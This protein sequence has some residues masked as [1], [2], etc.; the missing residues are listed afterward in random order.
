MKKQ[1]PAASQP[2]KKKVLMQAGFLRKADEFPDN[3]QHP[4]TRARI[5][6]SP[7]IHAAPLPRPF[8]SRRLSINRRIRRHRWNYGEDWAQ[9]GPSGMVPMDRLWPKAPSPRACYH[10]AGLPASGCEG[11]GGGGSE[12]G[13]GGGGGSE[14]GTEGAGGGC[15]GCGGG[16]CGGCGG[17]EGCSCGG[18]CGCG[19]SCGGPGGGAG[20][21]AGQGG[22]ANEGAQEGAQEGTQEGT[23]GGGFGAG[24]GQGQGAGFGAGPGGGTPG[25]CGSP[26]GGCSCAACGC[27]GDMCGA[28]ACGAC[29]CGGSCAGGG[30]TI[31]VGQG[32]LTAGC[33]TAADEAAMSGSPSDFGFGPESLG[34]GQSFGL[35]PGAY[36]SLAAQM[37]TP[38]QMDARAAVA[39]AS[40]SSFSLGP[41]S[42]P[43]TQAAVNNAIAA[44]PE[45]Q[46][47]AEQGQLTA[48][49]QVAFGPAPSFGIT[50]E[51]NP[52]VAFS[53]PQSSPC[54]PPVFQPPDASSSEFAAFADASGAAA[55][56]DVSTS[57]FAGSTGQQPGLDFAT[58]PF[59]NVQLASAA[60]DQPF[61]TTPFGPTTPQ[62][63]INQDFGDLPTGHPGEPG[64]PAPDVAPDLSFP[65]GFNT[66]VIPGNMAAAPN[67]IGGA[68]QPMGGDFASMPS[69]V[70]TGG[71]L[72]SLFGSLAPSGGTQVASLGPAALTPE[73][74]PSQASLAA[75]GGPGQALTPSSMAFMGGTS[76]PNAARTEIASQT[77]PPGGEPPPPPEP[78]AAA[79]EPAPE[80]DVVEPRS[81]TTPAAARDEEQRA[82]ELTAALVGGGYVPAGIDPTRAMQAG[83]RFT[84]TQDRGLGAGGLLQDM[85]PDLSRPEFQLPGAGNLD[86]LTIDPNAPENR[87]VGGFEG[88]PLSPPGTSQSLES[89]LGLFDIPPT[90]FDS[91]VAPTTPPAQAPLQTMPPSP[92]AAPTSPLSLPEQLGAP[93]IFTPPSGQPDLPTG[94]ILAPEPIAGG[95]TGRGDRGYGIGAAPTLDAFGIPT[96]P[97]IDLSVPG[98]ID[99]LQA[100]REA[101][102]G[103]FAPITQPE[104]GM[105]APPG[106]GVAPGSGQLTPNEWMSLQGLGGIP[107]EDIAA[108]D[109]PQIYAPGVGPLGATIPVN[110]ADPNAPYQ[111]GERGG[112]LGPYDAPAATMPGP[113]G[114]P[115]RPGG[116]EE[117]V[118][119]IWGPGQGPLG[120]TIPS[121]ESSIGDRIAA[122]LGITP[123][124]AA[125]RA[126]V[127]NLATTPVE[128]PPD[129]ASAGLL[130]PNI[131]PGAAGLY[132]GTNQQPFA[133]STGLGTFAPAPS[134]EPVV[135]MTTAP[136]ATPTAADPMAP[137]DVIGNFLAG[138]DPTSLADRLSQGALTAPDVANLTN[139]A[140]MTAPPNAAFPPGQLAPSQVNPFGIVA[141]APG[142]TQVAKD[143]TAASTTDLNAGDR[144]SN[145]FGPFGPGV[146]ATPVNPLALPPGPPP[147]ANVDERNAR[148]TSEIASQFE[149]AQQADRGLG[150]VAPTTDEL[151]TGGRIAAAD[152]LQEYYDQLARAAP[153]GQVTQGFPV[154]P[155]ERAPLG[156]LTAPAAADRLLAGGNF[157]MAGAGIGN[158]T[159]QQIADRVGN[160]PLSAQTVLGATTTVSPNTGFPQLDLPASER[161]AQ[162]FEPLPATGFGQSNAPPGVDLQSATGTTIPDTSLQAPPFDQ[163][164]NPPAQP[165][166][167]PPSQFTPMAQPPVPSFPGGVPLPQARPEGIPVPTAADPLAPYDVIGDWLTGGNRNAA[168]PVAAPL[169]AAMR[170]PQS[171]TGGDYNPPPGWTGTPILPPNVFTPA[172]RT[173]LAPLYDP[174]A[175]EEPP[176]ASATPPAP[177]G[178][179]EIGPERL[180]RPGEERPPFTGAPVPYPGIGGLPPL[181]MSDR[182]L[183]Q[184]RQEFGRMPQAPDIPLPTP[185]PDIPAPPQVTAPPS[186]E[187]IPTDR[188][189]YEGRPVYT[190]PAPSQAMPQ[191]APAAIVP[192][193]AGNIPV[194]VIQIGQALM[195]GG[196]P[197]TARGGVPMMEG[198]GGPNPPMRPDEALLAAQQ[199]RRRAALGDPT[200]IMQLQLL[201]L[202]LSGQDVATM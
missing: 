105:P 2:N 26:G 189:P 182:P 152:P 126:A 98:A 70:D 192:T 116:F 74:F 193:P 107:Y 57:E 69:T 167:V 113:E 81:E 108:R 37:A 122:L 123:A 24:Q 18:G 195:G 43:E 94:T 136:A 99:L 84:E 165:T 45:A 144:F 157:P 77:A 197:M 181:G 48:A 133:P 78:A 173:A 50:L 183:D 161:V 179:I 190:G 151:L 138:T 52:N 12:G 103:D 39:A 159:L 100:Q 142:V 194:S 172:E 8:V 25:G 146:E 180:E 67:D 14:G 21:G 85:Q 11:G 135:P 110:P 158:L 121:P 41:V 53:A 127:T 76:D 46:A 131:T 186:T 31:D 104:S 82:A 28:G 19:C 71:A 87:P 128:P 115:G 111:A 162:G 64:L 22:G 47:L 9:I 4:K 156:D 36:T 30:G 86:N 118:P 6:W 44:N 196:G 68:N 185:R 106:M 58:T 65:G 175:Y 134:G 201:N 120:P 80:P 171:I 174:S 75:Q 20:A 150:A 117:G 124:A 92:G 88:E 129:L 27:S 97:P 54:L 169:D 93:D 147:A 3:Y 79:P 145:V 170:G 72:A 154:T 66:N 29:N 96:T 73:G 15:G 149:R 177:T 187:T 38:S 200:A 132:T 102:R 148:L 191:T 163:N 13:G 184:L 42:S 202:M 35:A 63:V 55:A 137:Y 49:S 32:C 40:P 125:E 143:A 7:L 62:D 109:Q 188:P 33:Q 101:M 139:I 168:A 119:N 166:T 164:L 5:P 61:G 95:Y 160:V 56:P 130:D 83:D 176:F 34:Q 23:F 141:P 91:V 59:G 198:G 90:P 10:A 199:I 178:T 51:S 114:T 60:P 155:V 112:A 140:T 16:G 153:V 1:K 17:A 89:Q